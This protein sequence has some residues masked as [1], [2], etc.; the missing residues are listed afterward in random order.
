MYKALTKP[1]LFDE[2]TLFCL[3]RDPSAMREL[4]ISFSKVAHIVTI[5]ALDGLGYGYNCQS[6]SAKFSNTVPFL[7]TSL[8]LHIF[9]YY[10]HACAHMRT[11]H[12]NTHVEVSR[13][14]V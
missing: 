13:R 4:K 2:A 1:L 10:V 5:W 12:I 7:P 11:V 14:L 3:C 9:I 8:C 6:Q